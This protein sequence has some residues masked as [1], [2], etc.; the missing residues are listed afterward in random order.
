MLDLRACLA[1]QHPQLRIR[2]TEI[3]PEADPGVARRIFPLRCPH[4]VSI[5]MVS[6]KPLAM[7][8]LGYRSLL[9]TA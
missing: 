5:R 3:D 1:E 4:S 2:P 8:S 7:N 9:V 6:K